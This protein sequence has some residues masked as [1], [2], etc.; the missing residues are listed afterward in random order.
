VKEDCRQA[1]EKVY[2]YLDGELLS[3]AEREE[4]RAHLEDCP[5]C[6]ESY[7]VQSEVAAVVARLKG[8]AACPDRL[9]SKIAHFLQSD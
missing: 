8:S 2:L 1:L 7:G 5:P 6:L 3:E 4:I 9:K